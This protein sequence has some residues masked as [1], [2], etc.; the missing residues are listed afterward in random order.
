MYLSFLY[1]NV[2]LL[3]K[4]AALLITRIVTFTSVKIS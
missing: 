4:Y 1:K 2:V 3:T